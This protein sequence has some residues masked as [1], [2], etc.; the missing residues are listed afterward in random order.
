MP[1]NQQQL[2]AAKQRI[3]SYIF[4]TPVLFHPVID[5]ICGARVLFKCENLQKI[6]SFK[7]RGAINAVLSLSIEELKNGVA[8]HSSGNHAQALTLA[9]HYRKIPAHI[10]MPNNSPKTKVN[11]VRE[12]GGEIIFCE[13]TLAS[14]EESLEKVIQT[15]GA[16]FI[17]P[18]DHDLIIAGQATAAMELMG[19]YHGINAIIAPLGGGGLL[20]GTALA[21]RYLSP[22]TKVFGAEPEA[23]NDGQRSFRSGQLE[24]NAPDAKT[25]AD[26]LR[27][28]LSPLTLGYIRE[29]VT[30]I[31]TV[32][33]AEIID[34]MNLIWTR[35]KIIVEPSAAVPLA[36]LIKNKSSFKGQTVGIILSGGNVDLDQVPFL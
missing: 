31:N 9:A 35:L 4:K 5:A 15:T 29:H 11:G 22:G 32:S 2:Y 17:P 13:P 36:A 7:A 24:Q 34:A 1:I 19:E 30:D 10:V 18:Y 3:S 25:I 14:R 6:G 26:G 33:E 27:T 8:T 20:S 12:L 16:C 23:V 28:H 21:A